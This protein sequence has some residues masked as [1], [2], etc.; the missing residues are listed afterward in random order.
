MADEEPGVLGNMRRV[1][2]KSDRPTHGSELRQEIANAIG[3]SERP[4]GNTTVSEGPLPKNWREAVPY[5]VWV[6][7]VL[8]FG[9]E[10]VTAFVHGE[11]LHLIVSL[12]GLVVLMATALHWNALKSWASRTSPNWIWASFALALL[13]LIL[14][15]FIEQHRWPF[16]W[17][18]AQRT[19]TASDV[20]SGN[21]YADTGYDPNVPISWQPQF[22]I[23]HVMGG[24]DLQ[25]HGLYFQ[26]ISNSAVQMKEAYLISELTGHKEQLKANIAY[27]G[28][29]SVDQ[30]DVPM[31]ASVDLILDY[32][33][34]LSLKDF[35][36]Q[37]GAFHLTVIYN[38]ITYQKR[39][40]ENY[41]R[42][43]V[44]NTIPGVIGPR[45]T[46]KGQ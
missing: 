24:P 5:V 40:D 26:G 1:F 22:Q 31:G 2:T 16:A 14:A 42:G 46:P 21:T 17:Q 27:K 45:M 23:I 33:P 7:F 11:W 4:S 19:P 36:D 10:A 44:Q 9:L 12:V 41:V 29:F 43:L 35:L 39:Y 32:K 6:V 13:A 25:I 18:I 20:T 28:E 34:P 15:P 3:Q 37:W 30:V 8:G 38:G